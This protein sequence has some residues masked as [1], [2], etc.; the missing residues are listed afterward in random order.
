MWEQRAK[1]QQKKQRAIHTLKTSKKIG[2]R[3]EI[4]ML[5]VVFAIWW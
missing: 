3:R 5:K 4:E 1:Q 2:Y